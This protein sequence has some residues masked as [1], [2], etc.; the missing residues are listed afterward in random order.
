MALKFMDKDEIL[1]ILANQ[2]DVL[3]PAVR[4]RWEFFD[5]LRCPDCGG[6]VMEERTSRDMESPPADGMTPY[7]RARCIACRSLFDPITGLV[8]EMG[9][10]ANAIEP[11]VRI[12][13]KEGK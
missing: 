2:V 4:R 7:G 1:S 9:S 12:L 11:A 13:G 8:L 3:G 6:G 10:P 5:A